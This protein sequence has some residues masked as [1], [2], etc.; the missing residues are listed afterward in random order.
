MARFQTHSRDAL[1]KW[2]F[3]IALLV[4]GGAIAALRLWGWFGAPKDAAIISIHWTAWAAIVFAIATI[5]AYAFYAWRTPQS[6]VGIDQAAD[7]AYYLGLVFT[8]LSLVFALLQVSGL[9]DIR[10]TYSE[11]SERPK[12]VLDLLPDFGL[13]LLSTIAG[14]IARVVLQQRRSDIEDAEQRA[15]FELSYATA[16][17]RDKLYVAVG[18]FTNATRAATSAV[19][20]ITAHTQTTLK[21]AA[22]STADTV[23]EAGKQIGEAGAEFAAGAAAAT[24]R[25]QEFAEQSGKTMQKLQAQIEAVAEGWNEQ[26][27][28]SLDALSK[29][30]AESLNQLVVLGG[31]LLEQVYAQSEAAAEQ[32]RKQAARADAD[33]ARVGENLVALG[34]RA[35]DAQEKIAQLAAAGETFTRAFAELNG[36]MQ[37]ATR[38]AAEQ[39]DGVE[40]LIEQTKTAVADSARISGN[41]T[42]LGDRAAESQANVAQLAEAS[43]TFTRAFAELNR[44]LQDATKSAEQAATASSRKQKRKW[45]FWRRQG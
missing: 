2:E 16:E 22:D 23:R 44:V 19:D 26:H 29:Q 6:D 32:L 4:G 18:D 13:A 27:A 33:S 9:L 34:D 12:L 39:V 17:F 38:R 7:N 24:Q 31:K 28:A 25:M 1:D 42:A 20:S 5:V 35:A 37:N 30:G 43:E 21:A 11:S 41:L 10:T 45:R 40:Q 14:I 36:A 15:Q 3:F 8:L